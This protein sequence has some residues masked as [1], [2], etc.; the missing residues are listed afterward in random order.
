MTYAD[1]AGELTAKLLKLGL[2]QLPVP[3]KN[4]I[5][6]GMMEPGQNWHSNDGSMPLVDISVTLVRCSR[7]DNGRT[8]EKISPAK[9]RAWPACAAPAWAHKPRQSFIAPEVLRHVPI[10]VHSSKYCAADIARLRF[11]LICSSVSFCAQLYPKLRRPQFPGC[12]GTAR[13]LFSRPR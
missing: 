11:K 6:A 3:P 9:Y 7:S 5:R 1:G 13:G 4:Y 10:S 8:I 12:A 2:T